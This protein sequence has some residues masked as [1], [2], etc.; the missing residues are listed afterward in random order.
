MAYTYANLKTDLRSY[1]EV[2]DTV[3]TECY[4]YDYY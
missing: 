1:T 4:L 3:L 2:D